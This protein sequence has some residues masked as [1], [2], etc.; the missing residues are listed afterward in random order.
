MDTIHIL[1]QYCQTIYSSGTLRKLAESFKCCWANDKSFCSK[2]HF[3]YTKS[4]RLYLQLM[5]E[6]P[7][8]YPLLYNF[9]QQGYYTIRRSDRFL[10]GPWTDLAIEQSLMR[11]VKSCGG[12]TRGRGMTESVRL[13]SVNW[14]QMRRNS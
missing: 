5:D 12:L 14:T 13:L 11:T 3:Q 8:D 4:A 2:S 1:H 10:A 9:F 7:V 6:L